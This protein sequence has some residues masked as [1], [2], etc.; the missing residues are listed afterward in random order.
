MAITNA[1]TLAEYAAGISTQGATLT[2]D[3]NNKRVGI[4]TTNPQAMLQVGTGVTVFGNAGI[5]SFT[6][7]KL[8]GDTDSTSTSTGALTVTGGVGIGLS[9]TVGGDVSVGGTITY[10]DVTNVDSIGIVTAR[11]G[12]RVVGGGITCVG[13][14]T[15]FND[16]QVGDKIIHNGDTNTAIRFPTADT[17]TV[18]TGG[19]ERVR[20]N[21]TGM[22]VGIT[23]VKALNVVVGSGTTELIRLSQ[24][25][26]ASVQQNFGIGWCSNNN[27]VWPGAQITS[28]EYDASDTRRGLLFYTRGTNQDIAPTERLRIDSSGRVGINTTTLT[29]QLEVDG[30]IRVRNAVK[31]RDPNGD[32]TGAI[33]M[34]DDDNFTIQSFGTSGHIT[35]D[36]GSS[37]AERLRI[38]SAGKVGVGIT[39]PAEKFEVKSGNIAIVGGSSYKIDTHPLVT[40]ASFVLNGGN[41]ACRLG[42]TGS[43]T[44]RHTQIYGGGSHIATFD[45]VYNR[46]G[47]GVTNPEGS[48]TVARNEASG[49]IASF[50][51]VHA[52][53]SAQIMI[54]SPADNNTRPSS[55]D[56][57]NAGTVKWSLGQAYASASSGA[58]HVATSKLQSNDSGAK[59]T[60]TT[61]GKVGIGT[62]IPD[63]KLDVR[64]GDLILSS[65]NA[66]NA[67]RTSFIEF[68]G[69]YARINSVANQGSTGSSNYAAGWNITTR[70]YTGSAFETLTPITIEASGK[71]G[72][73]STSPANELIV[74]TK[75]G[76][77]HS[78][79]KVV[80]GNGASALTMQVIQ[81]AEARL[82]TDSGAPLALYSNGNEFARFQTTGELTLGTT[83]DAA[84]D[85]FASKLQVNSSNHTGSITIGRHTANAN[86]PALLFNKTRSGSNAPG[87]GAVSDDDTLGVI[88]W[89]GSD[90]TDYNSSAAEITCHVDT[91]PGTNDMPGRIQMGTTPDGESSPKES[92]RLDRTNSITG[93]AGGITHVAMDNLTTGY[94][95][96]PSWTQGSNNIAGDVW[97]TVLNVGTTEATWDLVSFEGST[98]AGLWCEITAYFSQITAG[99][100]GRQRVSYRIMRTGNSNFGT[101][102]DGP[103]DKVGTD[104]SDHFTP[105]ITTTGSGSGMRAKFRVTTT[106]LVNYCMTMYH[107]RWVAGDYMVSPYIIV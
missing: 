102:V 64:D 97:T 38:T 59:F 107:I 22:G 35:F 70:N 9:L 17:V 40:Y 82:G 91:T 74:M 24:T 12:L 15:F 63:E 47:V 29:E 1:S 89:Y 87:N 3:A 7:L 31:F 32:E 84:P 20:V 86:G 99:K 104:T 76:S 11:S 2:V 62:N 85:G 75:G 67:H 45:G 106:S 98:N 56:L 28:L 49:Y 42:S 69:S 103:Y 8:S 46:L 95:H 50:R 55:I 23:P 41:Y 57:A 94:A 21:D 71:I 105:S 60:I 51:S 44:I 43:S 93:G 34:G 27:H 33:D 30:D 53:N 10:E 100:A 25:V 36:T 66:A 72:I 37:A 78:C 26:D 81:G 88:R 92:F 19:S 14:A 54:D 39:N 48:L 18:E 101:S 83:T 61:A 13:V 52:S 16:I 4:G 5:A 80:S 73:N 65:S 68:T 58:F 6:S 79:A 96:M 90:G 77:G